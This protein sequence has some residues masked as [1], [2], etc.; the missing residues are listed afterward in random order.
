VTFC[1]AAGPQNKL[2]TTTNPRSSAPW[3]VTTLPF[4]I[5]DSAGDFPEGGG[6]IW[7]TSTTLC[8]MTGDS[9]RLFVSTRPTGGPNTWVPFSVGAFN[10]DS[11]DSVACRNRTLCI[12]G[13]V[14]N[15]R[16]AIST[17][18]TQAWRQFAL[19]P[20]GRSAPPITAVG[21]N[22][23]RGI[24]LVGTRTGALW[25]ST[26][27][28]RGRSAFR[29]IKLSS[30]AIVGIACKTQRLCF[31]IDQLGR[32]FWSTNPGGPLRTWS[33]KT[34]DSGNWPIGERLTAITCAQ[35]ASCLV[36]DAG[37]RVYSTP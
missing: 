10:N 11:W 4:I 5:M 20:G 30:R 26:H 21:C 1:A 29:R 23:D 16:L 36:G 8:V 13:G 27:P 9:N 2:L 19:L 22:R 12:A 24:C 25:T 3:R 17:A 37:G 33:H 35:G 7:C 31:A 34:L 18:P 32:A 14:Q 28:A 6:P 15:G